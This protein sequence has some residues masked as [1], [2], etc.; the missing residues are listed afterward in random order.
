MAHDLQDATEE[1]RMK[2][3]RLSFFIEEIFY[4]FSEKRIKMRETLIVIKS[5]PRNEKSLFCLKWKI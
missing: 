4:W 3:N 2:T 1:N 5:F